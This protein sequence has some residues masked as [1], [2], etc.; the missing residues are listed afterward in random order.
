MSRSWLPIGRF[1]GLTVRI[2]VTCGLGVALYLQVDPEEFVSSILSF[3]MWSLAVLSVFLFLTNF[4]MTVRWAVILEV[5]SESVTFLDLQKSIFLSMPFAQVLPSTLGADAARIWHVHAMAGV[6]IPKLIASVIV[7]RLA[8][9]GTLTLMCAVGVP[10]I[11][12]ITKNAVASLSIAVLSAVGMSV[13]TLVL[14]SNR[15]PGLPKRWGS[16]VGLISLR[17]YCRALVANPR[18]ISSAVA[19]SLII[20]YAIVVA[21]IVLASLGG[22][23]VEWWIFAAIVPPISLVS[24]IPI[25]VG[26]WGIREGGFVA[27]LALVGVPT[28]TALALG[29]ALGLVLAGASLLGGAGWLLLG[30]VTN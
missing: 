8:A 25:A 3:P 30:R 14:V 10:V 18:A 5:M 17:D 11:L 19:L 13:I 4:A 12:V 29:L 26:G 23:E 22:V 20:H 28:E 2:L 7:D 1:G 24:M 9:L 6:E 21:V 15:L 27:G 16:A